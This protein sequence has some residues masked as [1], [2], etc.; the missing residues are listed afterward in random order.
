MRAQRKGGRK[1]DKPQRENPNKD[2][3]CNHCNKKGHIKSTCWTKHPDKKPKSVKNRKSKQEGKSSIAAGAVEVNKE[4]IILTAVKDKNQ[5]MYLDNKKVFIDE[6]SIVEEVYTNKMQTIDITKAY[7]FCPVLGSDK[8]LDEEESDEE[9]LS[10]DD[11]H[12]IKFNR[13]NDDDDCNNQGCITS[14]GFV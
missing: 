9:F 5:Y 1:G 8:Y 4:E 3:T 6:E 12:A 10:N 13:N 2:E 7:H 14:I 11:E